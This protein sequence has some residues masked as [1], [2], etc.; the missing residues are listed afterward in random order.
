[1]KFMDYLK[2]T[3]LNEDYNPEVFEDELET[4]Q[5]A[6]NQD[7]IAREEQAGYKNQIEVLL[8]KYFIRGGDDAIKSIDGFAS[9]LR[10]AFSDFLQ[11]KW[12]TEKDFPGNANA[13]QKFINNMRQLTDVKNLPKLQEFLHSLGV[14]AQ[15]MYNATK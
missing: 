8:S 14:A 3:E 12:K 7:T 10:D 5:A 6:I 15:N 4:Q 1:M 9:D 2:N 13:Y 11:N